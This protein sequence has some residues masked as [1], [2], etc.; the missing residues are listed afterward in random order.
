MYEYTAKENAKI[1]Q[2]VVIYMSAKLKFGK[3]VTGNIFIKSI[4]NPCT[5]LSIKFPNPPVSIANS[6]YK[7]VLANI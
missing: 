7:V 1:T 2:P 6:E 5:N 3:F 4:T